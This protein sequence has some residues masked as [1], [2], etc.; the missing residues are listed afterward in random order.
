MI[1]VA[2]GTNNQEKLAI[3]LHDN[4]CRYNHA[5]ECF[6]FYEDSWEEPEH[7]VYHTRALRILMHLDIE[8]AVKFVKDMRGNAYIPIQGV[9][10]Q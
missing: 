10:Q 3:I 1:H 6:W 2:V 5:D 4:F 7:S 9:K 8:Q